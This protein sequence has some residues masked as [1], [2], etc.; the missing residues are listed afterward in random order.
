ML[1]ASLLQTLATNSPVLSLNRNL[2][3][4]I[5][6]ISHCES[7]IH[8]GTLTPFI[9][10][11][12]LFF[13]TPFALLILIFFCAGFNTFC[14]NISFKKNLNNHEAIITHL[15][16][17]NYQLILT[18]CCLMDPLNILNKYNHDL[19]CSHGTTKWQIL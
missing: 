13:S 12:F 8:K 19:Y 3:I 6:S 18:V 5:Y 7:E 15:F 17:H 14:T 2:I 4:K 1:T 9:P 10:Y 16:I 11:L